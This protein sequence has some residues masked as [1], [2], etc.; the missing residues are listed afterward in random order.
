MADVIVRPAMPADRPLVA[1]LHDDAWGGPVVV[2]HGVRYD[3][4]TLATLVA[5]D[6]I[7][8]VRGALAYAVDGDA[9]EVVSIVASPPGGGTGTALLAAAAGEGR[10]LGLRRLWLVTT[11]DNLRAL[12][13]YQRRGL[14]ITGVGVGAVDAA[15]ALKASI[16][17]VGADGIP[18]HDELILAMDLAVP[19]P[20][21]R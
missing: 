15:R 19:D 3:L 11:N 16:P 5:V 10:R 9:L 6:A 21:G 13:F 7:G 12:R 18:L 2:G 17:L 8:T 1:A 4:T 14:R 20:P